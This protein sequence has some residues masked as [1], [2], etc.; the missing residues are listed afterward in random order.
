MLSLTLT[1]SQPGNVSFFSKV[2]SE[3]NYDYLRFYIDGVQQGQW[4][5]LLNWEFHSYPVAAGTRTF[6]W[7]YVKDQ[8]VSTGSDCAWLDHI[9]FPA[10]NAP[11][12]PLQGSRPRRSRPP[13]CC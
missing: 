10:H 4:S 12:S 8:G 1:V 5:G 11:P 6:T 7:S 13:E 9:S 2:S 3:P